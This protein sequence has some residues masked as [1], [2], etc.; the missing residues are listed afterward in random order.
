MDGAIWTLN[1]E[2][3]GGELVDEKDNFLF[4]LGV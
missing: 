3:C 1:G 4:L 2:H